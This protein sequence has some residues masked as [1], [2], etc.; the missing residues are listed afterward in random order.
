M[1]PSID[2]SQGLGVRT[3]WAAKTPS[4]LDQADVPA[5]KAIRRGKACPLIWHARLTSNHSNPKGL[6]SALVDPWI[7]LARAPKIRIAAAV[8]VAVAGDLSSPEAPARA[9]TPHACVAFLARS[10]QGP[11]TARD[12]RRRHC[13]PP[14]PHA[15]DRVFNASA[16]STG[17]RPRVSAN[18]GVGVAGGSNRPFG[19]VDLGAK[20]N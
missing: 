14:F 11:P 16:A 1:S 15:L 17:S 2:A 13:I 18:L 3:P 6:G 5:R 12:A 8:P 9:P 10:Q 19:Q 7:R 4:G 20:A